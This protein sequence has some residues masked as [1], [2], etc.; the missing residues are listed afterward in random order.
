MFR[1]KLTII[2][3][4]SE[5]WEK[6]SKIAKLRKYTN[7]QIAN[8]LGVRKGQIESIIY[9]QTIRK[10]PFN[11]LIL[12]QKAWKYFKI[13]SKEL[14][15]TGF[16]YKRMAKILNKELHSKGFLPKQIKLH[17]DCLRHI[18]KNKLNLPK[19]SNRVN[20]HGFETYSK[21]IAN[22][23][24]NKDFITKEQL[25]KLMYNKFE[26]KKGSC[27]QIY[28]GLRWN[29]IIASSVQR[30]LKYRLVTWKNTTYKIEK[31]NNKDFIWFTGKGRFTNADLIKSILVEK[32]HPLTFGQ[33]IRE[34]KRK[35][36]FKIDGWDLGIIINNE[37]KRAKRLKTSPNID[38]ITHRIKNDLIFLYVAP[39]IIDLDKITP[40]TETKLV[41]NY[42]KDI[43]Y[44]L[45]GTVEG[46]ELEKC[47]KNI[48]CS[49]WNFKRDLVLENKKRPDL[50]KK[51]K[52][53]D[54]KKVVDTKTITSINE[55]YGKYADNIEIWY[56]NKKPETLV[57]K[58]PNI[59]LRPISEV[60][61]DIKKP[62]PKEIYG[63]YEHLKNK[64]LI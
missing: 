35:F 64:F 57:N 21:F 27:E 15:K 8:I 47:L 10:N 25:N 40:N 53:V 61:K 54:I 16:D 48:A 20:T 41:K 1:K 12:N 31:Y 56:L 39:G 44:H 11:I 50:I 3:K 29:K 19:R 46:K 51:D 62:I 45:K 13:K 22:I 43:K 63:D 59:I 4:N 34:I 17:P 24:K 38:L 58:S 28:M 6:V 55:K 5:M 30:P 18:L 2:K 23:L 32:G 14:F 37:R 9:R 42:K 49:L 7:Q 36:N 60:L 26:L 33:I 52:I